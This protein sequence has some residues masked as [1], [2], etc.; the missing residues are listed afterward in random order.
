MEASSVSRMLDGKVIP[1]P[2]A[3][4]G[5]AKAVGI[6][7]STLLELGGI[8]SPGSLT[9]SSSAR[10]PSVTPEEAATELG[11]DSGVEREMFL[12]MVDR[13]KARRPA[14]DADGGETPGGEVAQG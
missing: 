6:P 7:L 11:F 10:V 13:L 2:R 5:I 12:G 1:H 4:E 9:S 3:F 8:V 14:P